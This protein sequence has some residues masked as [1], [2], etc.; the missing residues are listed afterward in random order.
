MLN[1]VK[2]PGHIFPILSKEGGVLRRAGQTE[3]S[4]DISRIAALKPAGV[5]CEIMNEDGTMAR[6]NDLKKFAKTHNLT[7][8]SIAQLIQAD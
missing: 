7:I 1:S 6:R 8:V 4:V 3:G 2:V 5:I